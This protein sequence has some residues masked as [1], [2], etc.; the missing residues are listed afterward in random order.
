MTTQ[1]FPVLRGLGYS[2]HKKPLFSTKVAQHV[3]GREVRNNLYR[4]PIYEFEVTVE[5]LDSNNTFL[6]VGSNSLQTLM[7]FFMQMSG[8]YQ[9]FYFV[10]P[11]DYQA[12]NQSCYNLTTGTNTSQGVTNETFL[13]SRQF[14]GTGPWEPAGYVLNY[15]SGSTQVTPNLS[16]NL[17]PTIYSNGTAI[18]TS[19]YTI[20]AVGSGASGTYPT[21]DNCL[22]TFTT[23][24]TSGNVI[25][26]TYDFGFL[27]R[28]ND[29]QEDF[30]NIMNGLWTVGSLKFRSVKI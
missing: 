6:G 15:P 27:C 10:D 17:A 21:S 24:Q 4:Y 5:S 16:V 29:D 12:F 20:T 25:T 23:P 18:S 11:T 28:F 26:A 22:L 2:V 19:Q 9:T 14:N 30:E 3:S 13:I 1:Q 8:Q 7:S